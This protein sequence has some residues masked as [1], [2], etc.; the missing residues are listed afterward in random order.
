ML[1]NSARL[2]IAAALGIAA[3]ACR[4]SETQAPA[5]GATTVLTGARIIDGTGSPPV[6]Q[7]VILINEGR[8]AAAGPASDVQIP[9]GATRVDLAGKTVMPGLIDAHAHVR[10]D[11]KELPVRDDLVRRLRVLAAYGVTTV[12]SLG[13]NEDDAELAEVARLRDEQDQVPL[14]RAR[15]YTSGPTMR[16]L[17]TP[18]EGRATVNRRVEQK[19]DRIKFHLDG[20]AAQMTPDTYGAIIEQAHTHGLRASAHIYNL[21][22]AKGVVERGLDLIGHSVRDQDVDR[23]FIDA[24]KQ[25]DVPYVPTLTRELSVFVYEST[26]AFFSD[27]FFQR[28]MALYKEEVDLLSTPGYQQKVRESKTAQE[29]KEALVQANRNLKLLSDAGVPIAMG[30]DAGGGE[31]RWQ[32][33]FEHVEL[34]MMAKAGLTPMQ[35]IVAATGAAARASALDHVGTIAPGKAADLLVLDADPLQDILNTRKIHSVWIAGRRL[36]STGT[37]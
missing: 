26:P 32:G 22:D 25:R 33:Y 1:R 35:V 37:N 28:G 2:V 6:D 14:D 4:G 7:G 24:M 21:A 19:A 17:K 30:T 20:N 9:A 23:A 15:I 8:I 27:P 11:N 34:E 3:I 29:I 18:E 12:V 5:D 36:D 13:Q 16:N 31:G 10:A